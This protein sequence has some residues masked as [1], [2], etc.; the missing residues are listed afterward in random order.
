MSR[1]VEQIDKELREA[2]ANRRRAR[3]V[4]A[5]PGLPKVERDT[6]NVRVSLFDERIEHLLDERSQANLLDQLSAL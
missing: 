6:L 2:V 5:R 4:L 1:T 3:D